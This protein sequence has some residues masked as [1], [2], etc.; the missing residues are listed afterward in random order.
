MW[1]LGGDGR[2]RR[3]RVRNAEV[4]GSIPLPST[5]LSPNSS[6][7]YGPTPKSLRGGQARPGLHMA[8]STDRPAQATF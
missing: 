3:A 6:G 1:A 5:K 4:R 2:K 8:C 7:S